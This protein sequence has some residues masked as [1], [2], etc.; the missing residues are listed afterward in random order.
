MKR[1]PLLATLLLSSGVFA[2]PNSRPLREQRPAKDYPTMIVSSPLTIT[3][4]NLA[5]EST[6]RQSFNRKAMK[7]RKAQTRRAARRSYQP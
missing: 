3:K 6:Q 1:L 5:V 4:H 2:D 7:A